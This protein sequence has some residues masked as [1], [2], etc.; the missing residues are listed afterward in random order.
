MMKSATG[1]FFLLILSSSTKAFENYYSNVGSSI[2]PAC[3]TLAPI[4][5]VF[6]SG[7]KQTIASGVIQ[8]TTTLA[9]EQDV[10]VTIWQ[11]GC[12]ESGRRVVMV[13]LEVL[14]DFDGFPDLVNMPPIWAS[15]IAGD[16]NRKQMRPIAEE[17]NSYFTSDV[18]K[19]IPE[20]STVTFF[21]DVVSAFAAGFSMA[22]WMNP[23]QY[24]GSWTMEIQDP[25][26]G[27]WTADIPSYADTLRPARMTLTGR[28]SGTWVT[29]GASDQGFVLAFEELTSDI[30]GLLFMSWYTF[31]QNGNLIWLTG[32]NT[33]EIDGTTQVTVE[34]ELVT[35]G[36]FL[37]KKS[38]NRQIIGSATLVARDCNDLEL[39]YNLNEI[40]LG[41]GTIPLR[42][43]FSLEIQGYVCSDAATRVAHVNDGG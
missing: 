27:I 16:T 15:G 3:A 18:L 25:L 37:E 19:I 22:A 11:K 6:N 2:P 40:G 30:L 31:D 1:L 20:G 13:A 12:P 24:N 43:L 23:L 32:A 38:A 9:E 7:G 36:A 29:P 8:L 39:T 10:Q 33:Y 5:D 14:D 34:L 28:L 42:R 35:N 26:T 17:P 4:W 41:S 21:V